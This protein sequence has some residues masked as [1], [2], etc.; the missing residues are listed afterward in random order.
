MVTQKPSGGRQPCEGQLAHI[1]ALVADQE[2]GR[3][4]DGG[5]WRNKRRRIELNLA[6]LDIP[7]NGSHTNTAECVGQPRHVLRHC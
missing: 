2:Q 1:G 3:P 6:P 7:N 5:E 4:I